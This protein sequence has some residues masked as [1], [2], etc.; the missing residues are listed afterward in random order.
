M[1]RLCSIGVALALVT[2]TLM[3]SCGPASAADEIPIGALLPLSGSGASYGEQM[4]TGLRVWFDEINARGGIDGVK[5]KL[6]EV[7][8]KAAPKEGVNGMNKLAFVDKVPFTYSSYTTVTL[9]ALPIAQQAKVL[10]LNGGGTAPSLINA[11]PY[12]FNNMTNALLDVDID[13]NYAWSTL[14]L[15]RLA[16]L[17][18]NEEAGTTENALAVKTWKKLGGQAVASESFP[19]GTTDMRT[20]VSKIKA[21]NPDA[22]LVACAGNDTAVAINELRRQGVKAQ[23][24]GFAFHEIPEVIGIAKGA[25]EGFIYPVPMWDAKNPDNP[26]AK[27]FAGAY[28]ERYKKEPSM[29]SAVFYEGGQVLGELVK[30][31]RAQ[32]KPVTGE[33]LRE[34][35]LAIRT[36]QTVF[37]ELTFRPDGSVVK[38]MALKQVKDGQFTLIRKLTDDEM[39]KLLY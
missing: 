22:V 17:H 12:L 19:V 5:L 4:G 1:N 7:D 24:F 9:S 3:L 2:L 27:H 39:K 31:V 21:A 16:V 34:A 38:R 35:L 8:H 25:S 14:G 36:F 18:W 26:M 15:K 10:M 13:L 30:H 11:G 23:L 29:Y 33:N 6:I 32:K 37:G 28:R 20:Q